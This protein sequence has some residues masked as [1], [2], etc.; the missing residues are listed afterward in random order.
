MH[1]NYNYSH[2]ASQ[3]RSTRCSLNISSSRH[4]V[5]STRRWPGKVDIL[6]NAGLLGRL[7]WLLSFTSPLPPE[8]SE[9]ENRNN[10]REGDDAKRVEA[11]QE[12]EEALPTAG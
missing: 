5:K 12:P 6:P 7:F 9:N 3:V 2:E 1:A 8:I 11:S 4:R 10:G